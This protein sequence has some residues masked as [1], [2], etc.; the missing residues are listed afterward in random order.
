MT[1]LMFPPAYITIWEEISQFLDNITKW[2]E[3][4]ENNES[5]FF[6]EGGE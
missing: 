4:I 6:K 2:E 3:I 5:E 1:C